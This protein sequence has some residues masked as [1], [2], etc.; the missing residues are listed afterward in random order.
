[1]KIAEI[2]ELS[3]KELQERLIADTAAYNQ[4]K[5]SHSVSPLDNPASITH[6]RKSIAR[7]HTELRQRELTNK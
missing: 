3:T 4:K 6:L 7:M 1:M 2:R 5:V